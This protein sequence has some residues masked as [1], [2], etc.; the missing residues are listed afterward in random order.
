MFRWLAAKALGRLFPEWE[1]GAGISFYRFVCEGCGEHVVETDPGPTCASCDMGKEPAGTEPVGDTHEKRW[2]QYMSLYRNI[3]FGNGQGSWEGYRDAE[4]RLVRA[5]LEGDGEEEAL[6]SFRDS[7][8]SLYKERIRLHNLIRRFKEAGVTLSH[9]I[10]EEWS[11]DSHP[12][13]ELRRK[14]ST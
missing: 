10:V 1:G 13:R 8:C 6:E 7:V 4:R 3:F 12:I 5:V 9:G 2:K 14:R 11:E